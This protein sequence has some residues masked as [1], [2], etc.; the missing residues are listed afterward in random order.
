MGQLNE[1]YTNVRSTPSYSSKIQEFLRKN[2][3]SSMFRQ[4]RHHYPRRR[5]KA[6]YPYQ[7]MMSDTINYRRYAMPHNRNY[8]YIMVLIDVFSKRAVALPL[9]RLRDFDALLVLKN[10]ITELPDIP[11]TIITDLGTEYY[12][13][14]VKN[15][16]KQYGIKHY[17]IRGKHKACVA[18]RFIK[19]LKGRLERYFWEKKTHN[20]ID[21]LPQFIENYNNTYHRSIKMAPVEVN[22][23][24]R[25]EVFATMYPKLKD[26]TPPRLNKGDTVRILISKN[27][28]EKGYTRSWSEEIYVIEKAF[29][30]SSVDYYRIADLQGNT[31]PRNKYYWEL[32][33]VSKN[34]T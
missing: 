26:N 33:I 10:M 34:D 21:V 13:S 20:W 17:S 29:S 1:M 15:L 18:E 4:V 16:F 31:L 25:K 30:D 22:D 5:I 23:N 14:K 2:S 32:N 6:Y 28:F 8:K 7:I 12:N 11:K 9:K 3:T 24:N 27:I 19:T